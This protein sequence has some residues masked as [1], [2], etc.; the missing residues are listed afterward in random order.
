MYQFETEYEIFL[1][2]I[3]VVFTRDIFWNR[4]AICRRD[5]NVRQANGAWKIILSN[6]GGF[7]TQI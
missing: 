1:E 6:I 3:R 2:N 7:S 5:L 4:V